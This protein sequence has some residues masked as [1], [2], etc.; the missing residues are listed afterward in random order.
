MSGDKFET[1]SEDNSQ[2]E[3]SKSEATGESNPP[4]GVDSR[5]HCGTCTVAGCRCRADEI[6]R[7]A[8]KS[9]H[10]PECLLP[11]FEAG[12]WICICNQL[13]A[14]TNR[15]LAERA[16]SRDEPASYQAGVHTGLGKAIAAV[17]NELEFAMD[18]GYLKERAVEAIRKLRIGE[19]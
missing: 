10:L 5:T 11:D 2:A 12:K 17:E 13:Q 3:P 15:V 4:Q 1:C 18:P 6:P 9:S 7:G 16:E 14:C 19:Q 8:D